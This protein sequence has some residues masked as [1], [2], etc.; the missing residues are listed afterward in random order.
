MFFATSNKNFLFGKVK[1]TTANFYYYLNL[2]SQVYPQ[3]LNGGKSLDVGWPILDGEQLYILL[4]RCASPTLKPRRW[5]IT[6]L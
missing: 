5:P 2:I 6:F 3:L 1:Q 4:I